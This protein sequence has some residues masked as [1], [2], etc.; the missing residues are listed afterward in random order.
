MRKLLNWIT[1]SL[2]LLIAAEL[3]SQSPSVTWSANNWPKGISETVTYEVNGNHYELMISPDNGKAWIKELLPNGTEGKNVYYTDKWEKGINCAAAYSAGGNTYFFL[4]NPKNGHAW[5]NKVDKNGKKGNWTWKGTDWYKGIS[6]AEIAQVG[7]KNILILSQPKPGNI[8]HIELTDD[9]KIGKFLNAKIQWKNV[10]SIS[11]WNAGPN[12][13]VLYISGNG[14]AWINKLNEDG[15]LGEETW[16]TKGWNKNITAST[17]YQ[18]AGKNH[19]LLSRPEAGKAWI[20]E[21]TDDGKIGKHWWKTSHWQKGIQGVAAYN[22]DGVPYLFLSN[23]ETGWAWI[24]NNIGYLPKNLNQAKQLNGTYSKL[25]ETENKLASFRNKIRKEMLPSL[26]SLDNL[27]A[28]LNDTERRID[29]YMTALEP[30][31]IVPFVKRVSKLVSSTL[32]TVNNQIKKAHSLSANMNKTTVKP[33][34]KN[35]YGAFAATNNANHAILML[36]SKYIQAD[37]SGADASVINKLNRQESAIAEETS[38]LNGETNKLSK[39]SSH[40]KKIQKPVNKIKGGIKKVESKLKKVDNFIAKVNNALEK[41]FE[42]KILRKKISIS[43]RDIIDGK[44][45]MNGAVK[46]AAKKFAMK[47]LSPVLDK[48]KIDFDA[49]PGKKEIE[50]AFKEIKQKS[51]E[52]VDA[53][54]VLDKCAQNLVRLNGQI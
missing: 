7:D 13:Y 41:K 50:S 15:S 36:M 37:N 11:S 8:W 16:R 23:P 46:K 12:T 32:N 42:K 29:D 52:I 54:K 38:R 30:L 1:A 28:K 53:S 6:E 17:T 48:V 3:F 34:E 45:K 40:I 27:D 20:S 26:Y 24:F 25:L 43:V 39:I 51:A 33:T 47:L 10:H 35:T 19:V 2:F 49:F 5:I 18:F 9:G 14:E 44:K 22:V 31:N 21:L 4:S